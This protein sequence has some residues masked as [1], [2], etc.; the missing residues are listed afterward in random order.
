VSGSLAGHRVLVVEDEELI[1]LMLVDVLEDLGAAV[2]G[3]AA[4]V[5]E[6]LRLVA[7]NDATV[8][9]L[10]LSLKGETVY[11]V[12]DQLVELK[13]PFVFITGYGQGHLVAR[14]AQAHVLT[15][16][17]GADELVELFGRAGW[18]SNA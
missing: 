10:D 18:A 3:P 8:A 13:I 7:K 11:P 4:S 6:A 2:I 5:T 16:P 9:L 15:K 1:S 12:A 17:F 14:H